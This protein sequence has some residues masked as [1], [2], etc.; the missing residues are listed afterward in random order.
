MAATSYGMNL[1]KRDYKININQ[2][3]WVSPEET[4]LDS[5]SKHSDIEQPISGSIFSVVF[6]CMSVLTIVLL[7]MTVRLSIF[8]FKYLANLSFQNS[9]ANFFIPPPRGLVVD[10]SG[11]QLV[12]NYPRFDLLVISR[13]IKDNQEEILANL[14][15]ISEIMIIPAEVLKSSIFDG[16]RQSS[17]FIIAKNLTKD[18]L[19]ALNILSPKGFYVVPNV[20]RSYIDGPQFSQIMGYIGKVSKEDL[21]DKYYKSTDSIGRL[22]LEAMYENYLRGD[23]G[24]IFFSSDRD[25]ENTQSQDPKAGKNLVLN[26]DSELQRKLFS[27]LY[28]TLSSSGLNKG[29]AIIQN[30]N[31]GEVLALVS[32]PTFDNNLFVDGLTKKE[33]DR[34]FENKSRPLFNRIISGLYNPGSTV[35]PFYGMAILEENIFSSSDTIHDC[36]SLI[37]PNLYNP[38][39]PAVFNNW[40]AD[41]GLFNLRKAIA[42]SCNV[43]FFIGGGGYKNISGLG[44]KNIKKYLHLGLA[45]IK[46]DIDLPGEENG[47]I[48]DPNWKLRE[49]GEKW[50]QGDTYNISIGQGDLLVSPLW[51]N[52]YI[53]AIANGGTIYK[54][55]L[56]NQ[57]IDQNKNVIKSFEPQELTK[58][59]FKK[60]NIVEIRSDMEETVLSG[61]A[62]IFKDLPVRVAAKTGTAE[63]IKGM[64]VNSLFTAFA[65][66]ENPELA[67]TVLVEGSSTNQGLAIKVAHN[68]LKWYFTKK[69][70]R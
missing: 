36:V 10:R 14:Q 21:A 30:P 43:Y 3:D 4:L 28:E 52:S 8:D 69:I 35:K 7:I 15:G 46:L 11:I 16:I 1:F 39:D 64:R 32:F 6:V 13:E 19:L 31:T 41:L 54:P 59:P 63:I 47:F 12:K 58:L 65:P 33:F 20:K 24:K 22:G 51:I 23:H 70:S 67:L 66:Y 61:T 42:N 57:I 26:I 62:Q 53:S 17:A 50:Y 9:T 34:L 56:V 18:Q 40:R 60:E 55:Y 38:D 37:V 25:N 27:E 44:I 29:A 45:D 49:R 48:P 68:V 2:D 5:G